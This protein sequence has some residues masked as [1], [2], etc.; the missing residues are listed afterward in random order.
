MI[1]ATD[2]AECMHA[3]ST[4]Y[5]K[6]IVNKTLPISD[7]VNNR[8]GKCRFMFVFRKHYPLEGPTC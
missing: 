5:V 8:A 2:L 1:M 6:K 7:L 4:S 3:Y